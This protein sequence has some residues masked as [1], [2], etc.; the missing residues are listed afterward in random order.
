M[1]NAVG[2][3]GARASPPGLTTTCPRWRR[4]GTRRG[5]HLGPVGRRLPPRRRAAGRR[6]GNVVAVEVNLSCPN[7]EGRR[8]D[9]R[10]RPGSV[11]GG[12]RGASPC[13]TAPLGQAQRQHRPRRR[14]RR[15]PSSDAGAEAVTL[16]NTL[17]GMVHRPDIARGRRSAPA[18]AATAAGRSIRSPCARSS[19][20]TRR[21]PELP[22]IGVGGVPAAGTPSS[23]SSPVPARSRSAPPA[24]PTRGASLRML[25]ASSSHWCARAWGDIGRRARRR[26]SLTEWR[27]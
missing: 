18:A 21:C 8:G 15:P 11:R 27:A 13:A 23:C 6:T 3:A 16:I 20:S 9:L 5:Q 26:R 19:T 2:L 7:L 4:P 17:L 10:P 1:I 24:S 14:G 12:D 22:I 25:Q